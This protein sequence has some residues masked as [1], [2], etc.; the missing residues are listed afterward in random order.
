MVKRKS[1]QVTNDPQQ[2]AEATR[3]EQSE[4]EINQSP[5]PQ[6]QLL[7]LA[8]T[9]IIVTR[10]S[11]SVVLYANAEAERMFHGDRNA[12]IGQSSMPFYVNPDDR[13]PIMAGL[14]QSGYV[15]NHEIRLRRVDG[16]LFWALLSVQP[17]QFESESAA[18]LSTI[19]DITERKQAEEAAQLD[20]V[21]T[22]TLLDLN[23]MIGASLQEIAYFALE[24]ALKLTNSAIG[25][26]AFTNEDESILTMYAWSKSAMEICAIVDK[27]VD[28]PIETTGLWGEAV[29]QR[30]PV[31][32]NDYAAPSPLKRGHPEGH[33]PL[34]RHLNLPAFDGDHIVAV[35][36]VGNKAEDYTQD[37]VQ[38]L[39]VLI[40]GMWQLI[41]RQ[42]DEAG[43]REREAQLQ[44]V[45]ESVPG[46]VFQF[47]ATPEGEFGMNYVSEKAKELFGLKGD[48][49]TFFQEFSANIHEEDR[50]AFQLSI[51]KAI[52]AQ[53]PWDFQGKYTKPS[54]ETLWFHGLSTPTLQAGRL[55]FNGIM[56]DITERKQSEMRQRTILETM[57]I[58]VILTE[59]TAEGRVLYSNQEFARM[60]GKTPE[61]IIG[62]PV[63]D[64]YY[65]PEDRPK[66]LKEIREKGFI[67]NYPVHA[68]RADGNPLWVEL[69]IQPMQY[70]GAQ[71]LMVALTDITQRRAAEVEREQF[72]LQLN[73]A[74]AI[75]TQVS[76]I[77][78][79]D[80]LL[81]AVIP[82]IKERFG[83]YYVHVY[84]LD[85]KT[86]TLNLRA[87]YGEPG[88]IMLERGHSIPL[89]REQSLV[90]MA[91]RTK[92]LVHVPDVTKTANFLPNPLLSDTRTEVAVPLVV[93]DRVLGVFDIQ[94]DIPDYFTQ[95]YL[96]VFT[97]LAGQIA[98]ALQNAHAL[99]EVDH[100]RAFYDG[101]ITNLPVGVWAV[102]KQFTPLLVNPAGKAMMGREIQDKDGGAYVE[103]YDVI[104][105]ETGELYDNM[106][107]PLVKALTLGGIHS[108]RDAGV[109]QPDGTVVPMFINAA[110]LSDAEGVQTGAVVIFVDATEQR[111][112][113]DALA[114]R[115][116]LTEFSVEVGAT[117]SQPQALREI[118]QQCAEIMVKSLDVVLARVW[119]LGEAKNEIEL[120]A[121]AGLY[122]RLNGPHGHIAV[123]AGSKIGGIAL[124]R[125]PYQT[126]E[127]V[128]NLQ[129]S[130]D[131]QWAKKKKIGAFVGY[132]LLVGE[133][134]MGVLGVFSHQPL[135]E[136]E[137][138]TLGFIANSI[139]MG[140]DRKQAE[141]AMKA[142][143][144]RFRDV[145][146]NT[147]GWIWEVN[148]QG[149][150]TFC[151][152]KVMEV[153]GYSVAEML[154]K[155]PF[156]FMLPEEVERIAPV[157]GGIVSRKEDIVDLVNWNLRK[158]G[159]R[160]CLLTNGVAIVD[161]NG[162]LTGYRGVNTDITERILAEAERTKLASILENNLDLVSTATPDGQLTYLNP[163]GYRMVG[164]PED[165]GLE[166]H[167]IPDMHTAAASKIIEAEGV[168]VAIETGYWK[169]ETVVLRR[170]GV[171][172]AVEQI[173]M[174]HRSDDGKV[175]YMS[176]IMRDLTEAKR[177]QAAVEAS[178]VRQRSILDALPL[179]MHM[180]R[181]EPDGRL[182][183]TEANP[184]ADKLFE[185]DS[186]V[187]VG[188]TVEEIL[189]SRVGPEIARYYHEAAALGESKQ[190]EQV[191]YDKGKIQKVYEVYL[192]PTAPN[193]MAAGFL[194]VT[195]RSRA[196]VALESFATQLSTA[197]DIAGRVNAILDPDELLN[198]VIP[199]IKE[200]FDLYY[201]HVYALEG[202]TLTLRAGYGEPGRVMLE[203]GHS[204]PLDR[205]ASLVATAARTK[206]LVHVPDVT[207]NPNFMPNPLLPDTKTEV[208]VPLVVGGEV[209]G[210]FDI[211]HNIPNYFTESYLDVFTTLAG[212][213]ATALQNARVVEETEHQR[214][215]YDSILK[216]LP[217]GVWAVDQQF[218]VLLV[219]DAGRAMMGRE[220]ADAEGGSYTEAY[221]VI[222]I[223]TQELYDNA[224]LPLVKTV[225]QG[226][227]HIANDA[228]VR[229]PDGTIIPQMINSGPILD[230]QGKQIG[231]VVIF[232]DI[233]EQRRIQQEIERQRALYDG[234]LKNLPVGVW[235]VDQQFNILLVNDAGRTMMGREVANA[236]G[237]AYTEAYDV[238][239]IHTNELYDNAQLPLVKTV[240]QGGTYTA[241]DAGV[242]WPDGTVIPQMINSGPL[243]DPQGKQ[244]GGV[245]IFAD[246][247][248]QHLAQMEVEQL[249]QE[250]STRLAVSQ[251]LAGDLNEG[252][253]LDALVQQMGIFSDARVT[254]NLVD[255]D[256]EELTI[257]L[258]RAEAFQSGLEAKIPMGMRF[259]S[260]IM[261]ML[262]LIGPAQSFISQNLS[263]EERLDPTV[264]QLMAKQGA[265]SMAIIPM[266]SGT[267]W[268]GV[269]TIAAVK[270]NYF[271]QHKLHMYQTVAEQ[272][273][274]ALRIARLRGGIRRSLEQTSTRLAVSQA[275]AGN[276]S[277][278]EVLD[279]LIQ[280]TGVFSDARVTL[281]LIDT[282]AEELT[283]VLARAETFQSGLTAKVPLGTRFTNKIMPLLQ[284]I[285]PGKLFVSQNL[286]T[287]ERV[288]PMTKK[289]IAQQHT[290][291]MAIL[292]MT[293]GTEW[294]GAITIASDKEN[295]FD[296]HKLPLYETLA[297]QGA[298]ALRTARLRDGVQR[299][300][301]Q[302]SA[303][304]RVSQELASA[305]TEEQVLDA[306]IRVSNFYP[307]A[308]IGVFILDQKAEN[309]AVEVHR[310]ESFESNLAEAVKPGMRFAASEFPL[311]E[312]ISD[313]K[314]FISGDLLTD[315]RVDSA[316]RETA[317]QLGEHS[318]AAIPMNIGKEQL[319]FL[320]IGTAR[321]NFFDE[322]KMFLYESLAEQG[323]IALHA[324]HLRAELQA[325][326][327]RFEGFANNTTYGFGLADLSGSIL[328]ANTALYRMLQEDSAQAMVGQTIP[329]YVPE[330]LHGSFQN[331]ILPTLMQEGRWSGELTLLTT[332]GQRISTYENYFLIR[333]EAGQP[334]YIGDIITD[335]TE[336]KATDAERARLSA[337][338]EATSDTVS[339]AT[340]DGTGIYFNQSARKM[341]GIPPEANPGD[342][343]VAQLSPESDGAQAMNEVTQIAF[344]DGSWSGE[345]VLR[346]YDGRIIPILMTF[347]VIKDATGNPQ[348]IASIIR[349]ITSIRAAEA[350]RTRLSAV[351]EAT[352]DF[353]GIAGMDGVGVYFNRGAR[354][355]IGLPLEANPGDYNIA[356]ISPEREVARTM[357]EI[358][359]AAIKNGI[360]SGESAIK[361]LDGR[362]IP[363]LMTI[364]T[365]KDANGNPQ[366]LANVAR[367][368]SDIRA[369]QEQARLLA[370][371]VES[372]DEAILSA[373]TQ[374]TILS[375]NPAAE[376]ISGYTAA[377]MIGK[378]AVILTPANVRGRVGGM[379]QNL[380]QGESVAPLET[381]WM[382]KDGR[383]LDMLLSA[384]PIFDASGKVTAIAAM[385]SNITDRKRGEV[386][387]ERFTTQLSTAAEIAQSVGAILD[388]DELLNTVIPLL[389]E[390]FGLYH[391]HIYV[392]DTEM[393]ALRLRSG[394]GQVG[395]IMQQQGHKIA[396]DNERSLVARAARVKI[397]V[398]SNDVTQD[399]DFMPNLL[400]PETQSEVAVPFMIGDEVLGVFD[401][402]AAETNFF[403]EADLNVFR[404]LAGQIANA[405][406]SA[407]LFEQQR[408][409]QVA[410]REAAE[411][412]RAIFEAMNEGITVSNTLGQIEDLN[413]ATLHLHKYTD[414]NELL[415][416]SQMELFARNDWANASRGIRQALEKGRSE[417]A[418]YKML[419]KDGATFDAEQ[420]SALLHD[421]DGNPAGFVS[422]TRNI[423]E[424][425]RAEEALQLT[426]ASVD[427]TDAEIFWFGDDG[428]FTDVNDT[429]SKVLG[430]T[431]EELLEM[432]IFDIDRDF[433]RDS[434][435][436][437]LAEVRE[438]G[439]M[440]LTSSHRT[441]E[442]RTFPVEIDLYSVEFGKQRRYFVFARDI[443]E[444]LHAEAERERF[445]MQLRTA[446]EVSM[447][448]GA[449]LDP[450]KLLE[451]VVPLIAE[452]FALYHVHV[453]TVDEEAQ[454][455]V[456]RVGSGE[457]GRLMREQ[458]HAIPLDREQSLVARVTRTQKAILVNDV[459]QEPGFMHNP[460][461][462][463]TRSEL[464]VPLIVSE[465]V[466]GVL[467]VQDDEAQRFTQNDMDVFTTLAG[468]IAAAFL[469]ATSYNRVLEV[470]RLKGEF[471]ANMSH[472]L[473]TPL[474]SILGYTEV[475]LM[476]IDGDLT[477]EMSEDVQAIFEN[478]QQLLRLINDILDLTKIEAG[479]MVLTLEPVDIVPLLED[480]KVNNQGLLLKRKT[481]VEIVIEAND[482]LPIIIADRVRLGQILNN[483]VSNAVK[484]TEKGY[485]YLRA[486][487]A[488]NHVYIEVEDT[489]MGISKEDQAKIFQRFRQ[490][491][492]SSTRRAEGTGLGLAITRS[493]V[494]MHGWELTLTSEAGKGS[495]FNIGIPLTDTPNESE[496]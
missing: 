288:D 444:R 374:G 303:R 67:K 272:G 118:L 14:R 260:K 294:L 120:Q 335:I 496:L 433:P 110:P 100:Q 200:R 33:V 329:Q 326:V 377:E 207:V 246:A 117:L 173:I 149:Q 27:P 50:E 11:D 257:V 81:Q 490:V 237:G 151:S 113:Q 281:N 38:Q 417:T 223:D 99:T 183:F 244:M 279:I 437:I 292:P 43:L 64:L 322:R 371:I 122:T 412:I 119:V 25:Y 191:I 127:I 112:A 226:G 189:P 192:F 455:L 256:A 7:E 397:A 114:E 63:P 477:P 142:S 407:R 178:T 102:D 62:Q 306:I 328:Y 482:D 305:Q 9:G 318:M 250:T 432:E 373:S 364:I 466:L 357:N 380:M 478:G 273:A 387:R 197:S 116:R 59:P 137:L 21:R 396:L 148:S 215:L 442:G 219:N 400:L 30:R 271:D 126:T 346:T 175:Q 68:K 26:L 277:E 216:N 123:S 17:V 383:I 242:R 193:E 3:H 95:S 124:Q 463:D 488:E 487:S 61:T 161:E 492:G 133:Q 413:E 92:E 253:V 378:S 239:N 361:T 370:A 393:Q 111:A 258:A 376:R 293:A 440:T 353:V 93:G 232:A 415:G 105:I 40:Q 479:R 13:T 390:R 23:Q 97:T 323:A 234:I 495:K 251:A 159:T 154:G 276:L 382:T 218:N 134:I 19:I 269:I 125:E 194:D 394:Y 359:P 72:T 438:T 8:V 392:L 186:N 297:E 73:T 227:I 423:T 375:W 204:I 446:A 460:L 214:A 471:L 85:E 71:V 31:I 414:R 352:S 166:G 66:V 240:T 157:F 483:L 182:V 202:T 354:E 76:A 284:H 47:Y 170:D 459:T 35:I 456:M 146:T 403:T 29:R 150:Y 388:T 57:P 165:E 314:T 28:Y 262:H 367:D 365:I 450:Q 484:F 252:E 468:Q 176:T 356:M 422:I 167:K 206:Q 263:T 299:S 298:N 332:E 419:C 245:V 174:M 290:V 286:S 331:K 199:L 108:T 79:P 491:D 308:Q 270:D 338:I 325:S 448:V 445:T 121:S 464:A 74:A 101:I 405:F 327:A 350:E 12:L 60:I 421:A 330:E 401:V 398:V 467:D 143:E 53:L 94:H 379:L 300:L 324:A 78:D 90:A 75:A 230:P 156:D 268:L 196:R 179:G 115:V 275:L 428:K 360:W 203:Q 347:I 261:P 241:T 77:L 152:E 168:P 210:V 336:R 141:A 185:V 181:L 147:P 311:V 46:V 301:A 180:Y 248:Q 10:M 15:R 55:I 209:L 56:L 369:A 309:P 351:L 211:Q 265:L 249:L 187:F 358:I 436:K 430:Y 34:K 172:V 355:M 489:G 82:L 208:A 128:G 282:E 304:L 368:I 385:V 280:Q 228:G 439:T 395:K 140:I 426:R 411:R 171:E 22:Q 443:T 404:T 69:A 285:G 247:T 177:A 88:R 65:D 333:D 198:T 229:W 344:K 235:A 220:V 238:I 386:E 107:L 427:A 494:Q 431:R 283:M 316:S 348:Y 84:L 205:E 493:L 469:T 49:S 424:R 457:I 86:S 416:R 217:V 453:Y 312:L 190:T 1:S 334:R 153:L 184:S 389:K 212:Q 91:A 470:D 267:E 233:T 254:L 345:N 132:P 70:E 349:D 451:L 109:R 236:E 462:P 406:Q 435:S 287:D 381:Q 302:T 42:K 6:Q 339:I 20:R 266:T 418:E 447:Q 144:T 391:A 138:Q 39:T 2:K 363:T 343:N 136:S 289:L 16:E 231:G 131:P 474:N 188:K 472:E 384:S 264:R 222:N 362:E 83:L 32:T 145:A 399:P 341:L 481:S 315:E 24:G 164:W 104:N 54:G 278:E 402:Q 429:A 18:L 295:Y 96:D 274:N 441:K 37:D 225:T 129:A 454:T 319:G 317:R 434:L 106:Q 372:A 163:A 259:T 485:I 408:K 213:I 307:E 255:P 155:T 224:Q 45:A 486:F 310:I 162:N 87:G 4:T 461:L 139:A 465:K 473:R 36:G 195:E 409:A 169:G 476:G 44:G 366:Y 98:V 458:T 320:T 201:I 5:H 51:Q 160:I 296:E 340:P 80:R 452:R 135:K 103:S 130:D 221:D 480:S 410:Q 41:R 158:D 58:G 89:S 425:K 313:G 342:Y 475:M 243:L 48:L 420:N 291:S 337:V 449:I 321:I 52:T